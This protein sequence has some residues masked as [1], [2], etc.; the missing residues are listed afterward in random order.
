MT[1]TEPV[2]DRNLTLWPLS[3][4]GALLRLLDLKTMPGVLIVC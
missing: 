1:E 3:E 2:P 4:L